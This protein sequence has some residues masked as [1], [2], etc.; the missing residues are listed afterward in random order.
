MKKYEDEYEPNPCELA[1]RAFGK[2]RVCNKSCPAYFIP[3]PKLIMED[4]SEEKSRFTDR[5]DSK[6]VEEALVAMEKVLKLK[7]KK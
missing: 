5:T 3:C 6:A 7:V 4:A 1:K 2:D